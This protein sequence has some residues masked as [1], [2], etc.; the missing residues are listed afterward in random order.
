M[1]KIFR[2]NQKYFLIF[3]RY[4]NLCSSRPYQMT[5]KKDIVIT[6]LGI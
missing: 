1:K 4:V 5:S 3:K 2:T 6:I